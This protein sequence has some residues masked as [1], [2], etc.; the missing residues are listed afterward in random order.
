[1]QTKDKYYTDKKYI[2][3]LYKCFYDLHNILVDNNIIYFA[4]GGSLLGAVRHKGIIQ[5]DDDVDLEISSKDVP[6]ILK[7]K[8]TFKKLGYKVVKHSESGD[9][10]W[11]KIN[12][13]KKVDGK[14]SSIDLFPIYIEKDRTHFESEFTSGIWPNAY[15]KLKDLFPLK[16]LKFGSGVIIC[17]NNPL[18]YLDRTYGK[19][20]IKVGY[21]T[22]DKNHYQLEKPIKVQTGDFKSAKEYADSSKQIKLR[23]NHHMLTTLGSVFYN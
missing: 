17:P 1:M 22:M 16:Q 20:W 7:L 6:L 2:Q 9:T 23:K 4:S 3:F 5:W 15:H 18:P 21:I 11:I 10:D 13:I 19:S 8:D 12:S 14:I